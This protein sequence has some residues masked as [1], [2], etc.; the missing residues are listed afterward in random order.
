MRRTV[1]AMANSNGGWI[2]FGVKDRATGKPARD[3]VVGIPL[4]S[5]LRREFGDKLAG[6]VQEVAFDASPT[7]IGVSGLPG[8]GIFI[9][10]IPV[11]LR[12]PHQVTES[13]VFHRR[14]DGGAAVAM[15]FTRSETKCCW[16]RIDGAS[17]IYFA[18]KSECT[19]R[20]PS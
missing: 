11:S 2:V 12:R 15:S 9:V 3:R 5:D 18:S 19:G 10:R 7:P 17:S 16:A 4:G 8:Q 13:G 20:S 14:G 1:C 6:I